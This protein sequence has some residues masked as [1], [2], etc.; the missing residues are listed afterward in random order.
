MDRK[1]LVKILSDHLGVKAKYL[2]VPSFAY[3][4]GDFTISRD[5]E[6]LN[7]AGD[8]MNLDEI[9]SPSSE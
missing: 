4:V 6:I 1:K 3:Q 2:G 5:G 8:E 9:L 7:K